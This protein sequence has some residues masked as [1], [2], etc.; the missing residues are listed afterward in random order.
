MPYLQLFPTITYSTHCYRLGLQFTTLLDK[1]MTA[2]IYK[3]LRRINKKITTTP[4]VC[5]LPL[6]E[7]SMQSH[8]FFLHILF[9]LPR[10]SFPSFLYPLFKMQLECHFFR[11]AFPVS[12]PIPSATW[13]LCPSSCPPHF[14]HSC[15]RVLIT[16]QSTYYYVYLLACLPP[17]TGDEP[18]KGKDGVFLEFSAPGTI[19]GA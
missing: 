5:A 4:K 8:L 17:P 9:P 2:L 12:F 3:E 16:L 7:C 19:P 1:G 18:L 11:G 6:L 10:I 14:V 13:K 15:I